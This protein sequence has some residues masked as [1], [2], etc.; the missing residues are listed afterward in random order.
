MS[1][2]DFNYVERPD[3]DDTDTIKKRPAWRVN[4]EQQRQCDTWQIV[5]RNC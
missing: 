1:F 3:L 5:R 4:P 2:S